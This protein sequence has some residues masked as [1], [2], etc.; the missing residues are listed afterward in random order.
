MM[1]GMCGT[2]AFALSELRSLVPLNHRALPCAKVFH[3]V[4]VMK[5]KPTGSESFYSI[6]IRRALQNCTIQ[7]CERAK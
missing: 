2:D 3:T 6:S 7:E 4:G 5:R 1:N